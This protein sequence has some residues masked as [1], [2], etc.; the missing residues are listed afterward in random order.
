MFRGFL[1]CLILAVGPARALD[2]TPFMDERELEGFRIP[3]V[4]FG[5]GTR[6]VSYRPPDKWRVAGNETDLNLIP[7]NRT[8]CAVKLSV[9]PRPP[10]LQ[11]GSD[12]RDELKKW[13]RN[14][15]P[16]D[17]AEVAVLSE[18]ASPF[19]MGR[20]VSHEFVFGYESRAAHFVRSV[21]VVDLSDKQR[22]IVMVDAR[23]EDF[24]SLHKETIASMFS[25]EWDD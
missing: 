7:P 10:G 18:N 13:A 1:V 23:P 25:W 12:P 15:L 14:L 8:G 4:R 20:L 17:A 3:I 2:L 19:M 5:D 11:E 24:E 9:R 22:F 6:R 16:A 21:A